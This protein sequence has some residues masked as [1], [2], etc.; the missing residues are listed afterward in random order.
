MRQDSITLFTVDVNQEDILLPDSMLMQSKTSILNYLHNS[1]GINHM[2]YNPYVIIL[3]PDRVSNGVYGSELLSDQIYQVRG[4]LLDASTGAKISNGTIIVDEVEMLV[5]TDSSGYFEFTLPTGRYAVKAIGPGTLTSNF[6]LEV[7]RDVN[8]NIELFER[9][10]ELDEIIISVSNPEANVVSLEPGSLRLEISEL[11]EMPAFLG[12]VDVTRAVISL[13][14]VSSVGEGATGFNVRGGNIDQN[15]I[16]MDGIPLFNSSHLL[17]FFSAFN[18]DLIRDF[19]L[20]K[21]LIPADKG[22]RISSVLEVNQK[23]PNKSSVGVGASVGPLNSKLF[24]D[25]PVKKESSGIVLGLRGAY[26]N[27]VLRSFP[28][29]SEASNGRASFYDI[30]FKYDH[31]FDRSQVLT[32]NFYLSEDKFKL[33]D[34]TTFNYSSILAGLNYTTSINE[35][36]SLRLETTW[37]RYRAGIDDQTLN[38]TSEFVNGISQASLKGM[39]F[40]N[41]QRTSYH[42]GFETNLYQFLTGKLVPANS[43]SE[44]SPQIMPDRNALDISL[45]VG[46]QHE[47]NHRVGIQAGL[48]ATSFF[49]LGPDLIPVFSP[50]S[51]KDPEY[52]VDTTT[53]DKG[54]FDNLR[55]SFEPRFSANFRL[56]PNTSL[57]AGYSRTYQ[58]IHLFSNTVAS[59]PTDLWRPSDT[60]LK[61]ISAHLLSFGLFRNFKENLLETSVEVFYKDISN[62]IDFVGGTRVLLNPELVFQTLQGASEAYGLELSIHKTRGKFTGRL[63]YT[64]SRSWSRFQSDIDRQ[65]LNDGEKFPANFD[66]P[67]DLNLFGNWKLGRLWSASA[68]F[69][70]TSGRPVSLPEQSFRFGGAIVYSQIDRNNFRVPDFHRLDLAVTLEGSNKKKGKFSTSWTFSVYN[71]YGRKNVFSV[72]ING[73]DGRP[74]QLSVLGAPFPS[75]TFNLTMN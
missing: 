71:V 27:Y 15:L 21:G 52:V 18:P 1:L 6:D 62:T 47:I 32:T 44:V 12:E 48:R 37:S 29:E 22:G 68:N 60:N 56:N 9:T 25:V 42:A 61:P 35:L 40:T 41:H 11:K 69:A 24:L 38:Q 65:N 53:L 59:L 34:D 23:G 46:V 14:G 73:E 67:H 2:F 43:Q 13:P 36:W 7:D 54:E 72:F 70:Y 10:V 19:T 50:E 39:M 17:G 16:L 49:N 64:F 28:D 33:S 30:T 4:R 8:V 75:L 55:L 20:Y 3:Y 31:E 26:P 5:N 57:K 51:S 45:F 58:Y 63:G 74:R 66:R